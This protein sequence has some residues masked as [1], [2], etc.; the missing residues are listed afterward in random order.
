MT[1]LIQAEP[2]AVTMLVSVMVWI[3]TGTQN[4]NTYVCLPKSSKTSFD[5]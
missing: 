2:V 3:V 5:N 1:D 4:W